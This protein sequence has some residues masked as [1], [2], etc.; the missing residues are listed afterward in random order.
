MKVLRTCGTAAAGLLLCL[1][2]TYALVSCGADEGGELGPAQLAGA[3][4]GSGGGRVEF[5]A[6][7]RFEMSGIPRDAVVFSFSEPPP[8]DGRLS[9][10]GEWELDGGDEKSGTI[11]LLFDAGGSFPDDSEA[12]LLQVKETGEHPVLYFDTNPDKAYGYEVRRVRAG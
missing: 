12:T 4:Q 10:R 5:G 7:G 1:A 8:G 11:E 6:D 2:G 9:G 3:W